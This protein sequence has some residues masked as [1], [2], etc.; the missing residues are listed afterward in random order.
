MPSEQ[1]LYGRKPVASLIA[2]RVERICEIYC[3]DSAKL[4]PLV[5]DAIGRF[6]VTGGLVHKVPM[7]EIESF[8]PQLNHQGLLAVLNP[9]SPVDLDRLLQASLS[10]REVILV[11]DQVSDPHNLGSILRAAE[12]F[13]V[14]G[15]VLTS[16]NS[17]SVTPVV[18]KASSGASEIV[19]ICYVKNL[20]RALEQ[21]KSAGFWLVGTALDEVSVDIREHAFDGP[22]AVV[23]GSEGKG[24]RKLTKA[25]CDFLVKIPQLGHLESLNVG[26]AAAVV[27]YEVIRAKVN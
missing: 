15:V 9:R 21:M 26:Q 23:L 5:Q 10:S 19:D 17:A 11:L 20:S 18:R 7:A 13:G 12:V 1:V 27:L 2:H 6:A 3:A 24:L 25:K 14:D 8:L 22:L 16:A 4:E